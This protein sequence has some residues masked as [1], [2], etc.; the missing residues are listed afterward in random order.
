ML[1]FYKTYKI[2]MQQKE[3]IMN[4][5]KFKGK[6][7]IRLELAIVIVLA[8]VVVFVFIFPRFD[9]ESTIEK[10]STIYFVES[11]DIPTIKLQEMNIPAP[12][13]V[14]PVMDEETDIPIDSTL[15]VWEFEKYVAQ[16]APPPP[17]P[18]GQ[19]PPP[20]VFVPFDEP[21]KPIGGIAAIAKNTI[22]PQTAKEVG[23]EGTIYTQTYIDE[24][25]LV[26]ACLINKGMPGTGLDEAAIAAIK[27]T[28]W[29][30]AL[31]RDRKVGVWIAIPV[32]FK[33]NK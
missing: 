10:E 16:D 2:N 5:Q 8:L 25:G 9:R 29:K 6:S 30:P 19:L 23:I 26:A 14:I 11:L 32:T 21:P 13:P 31:Q 3:K 12:K 7:R 17:L 1:R 22:Y 33:M 4:Y 24:K 27:K 15:F 28:K 20:D 18:D